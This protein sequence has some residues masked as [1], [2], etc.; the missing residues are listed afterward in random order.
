MNLLLR[1]FLA[2]DFIFYRMAN[3]L[4]DLW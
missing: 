4:S 2:D 3:K 1:Y